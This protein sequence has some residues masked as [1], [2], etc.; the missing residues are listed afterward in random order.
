MN[1]TKEVKALLVTQHLC[2]MA[3]CWEQEPYVSLMNFTFLENESK[4]ILSTRKDSK[5]YH[6][7]QHNKN[8]SLLIY[9]ETDGISITL[10]GTASIPGADEEAIYKA[11]HLE[12]NESPQFILGENVGIIV[13]DIERIVVSN[14]LDQVMYI[15]SES[16]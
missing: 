3:T 6:N 4:V 9:S 10:L 11:L 16:E 5:K 13:F 7:V 1:L 14:Y 8:M 15:D 2:M 12:K